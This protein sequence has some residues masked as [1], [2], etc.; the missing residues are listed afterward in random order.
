VQAGM[1]ADIGLGE[2]KKSTEKSGILH[3]ITWVQWLSG[4][5]IRLAFRRTLLIGISTDHSPH[6]YIPCS[7]R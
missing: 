1:N 5:S 2:G 4:K 7:D 3:H 6:S